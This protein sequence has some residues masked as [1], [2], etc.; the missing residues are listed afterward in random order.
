MAYRVCLAEDPRRVD[1][2]GLEKH[3]IVRQ[4]A[5]IGRGL[6]LVPGDHARLGEVTRD[7][8]PMSIAAGNP[9]RVIRQRGDR[10]KV[11]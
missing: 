9:A 4:N 1:D 3:L 8:P 2:N 7:L 5:Y 10:F 6:R 11:T